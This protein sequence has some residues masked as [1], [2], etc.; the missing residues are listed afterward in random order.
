[1]PVLGFWDLLII[2][3]LVLIV[4]GPKRL[5]QM[6]KSMGGAIKGFKDSVTGRMDKLDAEAEEEKKQAEKQPQ[7]LPQAPPQQPAPPQP[8]HD[9]RERDTVL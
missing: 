4:F 6:G 9:P 8:A 3:F 7:A 1:M 5:P 2:G